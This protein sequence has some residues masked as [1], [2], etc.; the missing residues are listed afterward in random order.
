MGTNGQSYVDYQ[1]HLLVTQKKNAAQR[2]WC[3]LCA[4]SGFIFIFYVII[5][6]FLAAHSSQEIASVSQ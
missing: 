6:S 3:G 1:R 2:M 4:N 5:L